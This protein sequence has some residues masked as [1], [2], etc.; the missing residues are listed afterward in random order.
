MKLSVNPKRLTLLTLGAGGLGLVLR[1]WYFASRDAKGLLASAHFANTLCYLLLAAALALIV[2]CVRHLPNG[3]R[4]GRLFS[5]GKLPAAGCFAGAAGILYTCIAETSSQVALSGAGLVLG[6]LAVGC[7]I[8]IGL[9]RLKG[10]RPSVYLF[11]ILALYLIVHVLMQVRQW[12]KETQQ[13]VIFFPLMASLFLLVCIYYHAQL[14]LKQEGV[15]HFVFFQQ[16]AMLLCC[17]CLNSD[18]TVLYLSMAAWLGCDLCLPTP[19]KPHRE[20]E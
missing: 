17:M 19:A 11:A 13:T 1:I 15:R 20:E 2:L 5:G 14:A 8:L 9:L 4:Y 6:L 10:Q 16:A 12:N 7:L 18:C 3:G